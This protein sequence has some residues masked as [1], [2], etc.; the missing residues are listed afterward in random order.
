MTLDHLPLERPLVFFDLETTGVDVVNDRVVQIGALRYEPG[1]GEPVRYKRLVH[2]GRPIPAE[3][4]AI[5]GIS[6]ADVADA[7]RFEAL[8]DELLELF[9]GAD[10]GG[11]NVGKFDL[12]LLLEEFARCGRRFETAGRRVVDSLEL[13]YRMEPR[14]LAGALRFYCGEEMTDAHDAMADIEA[15]VKVLNGQ[16]RRYVP[17]GRLTADVARLHELSTR[18]GQLDATNRLRRDG[19]GEIVFNFGKY[20]GKRAREVF[21]KEPSYYHW[22]QDKDFSVQVKAY[23]KELWESMR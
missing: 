9:D 4:T 5:H 20:R 22:I 11:Y 15:T 12:P 8:A 3:T 19:D 18:P 13:F 21:R 7:P 17:D 10:V 14:T 2:P 6:D 1:G 16:L 23:T